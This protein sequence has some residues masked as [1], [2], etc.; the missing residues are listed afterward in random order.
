MKRQ[1]ILTVES[2]DNPSTRLMLKSLYENDAFRDFEVHHCF[3]EEAS[4]A[5]KLYSTLEKSVSECK[6]SAV[7]IHTGLEFYRR[8]HDF[9]DALQKL[10]VDFPRLKIGIQNRKQQGESI[11]KL[12][13]N[14]RHLKALERKFFRID[15]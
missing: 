15:R 7:L 3:I 10:V 14:D 1:T 13:S 2:Y 5:K 9:E 6:P 4:T 11:Q 8:A 12:I